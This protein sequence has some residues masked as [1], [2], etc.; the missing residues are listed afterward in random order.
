[1][2]VA[3]AAC[4]T[5]PGPSHEATP[6]SLPTALEDTILPLQM[7]QLNLNNLFKVRQL[8]KGGDVIFLF[9]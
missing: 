1:M 9:F 6:L 4:K 8:E 7:R 2:Y 5:V 3:S